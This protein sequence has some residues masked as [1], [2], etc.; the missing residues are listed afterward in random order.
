MIMEDFHKDIIIIIYN[1]KLFF[2]NKEITCRH[3]YKINKNE[4]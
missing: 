2:F 4:I 1:D 3:F